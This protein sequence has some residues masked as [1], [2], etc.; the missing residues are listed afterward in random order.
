LL[1]HFSEVRFD[2]DDVDNIELRVTF[3]AL[4]ECR[5]E[6]ISTLCA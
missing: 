2:I 5:H 3:N 1:Q 4:C 6:I